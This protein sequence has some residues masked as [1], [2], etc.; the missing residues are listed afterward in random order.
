MARGSLTIICVRRQPGQPTRARDIPAE[1]D[2]RVAVDASVAAI[3][4]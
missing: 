3:T 1:I 4:E 2:A